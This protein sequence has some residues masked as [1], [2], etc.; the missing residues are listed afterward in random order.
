M[1]IG[2]FPGRRRARQRSAE[3]EKI[4]RELDALLERPVAIDGGAEVRKF[5]REL[6]A[7]A[8]TGRRLLF[9]ATVDG[10]GMRGAASLEGVAVD[11]VLAACAERW[12]DG[13]R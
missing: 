5:I 7:G 9:E 12:P 13:E 1:G 6:R 3:E 2:G 8:Q 4:V 10:S 11:Q